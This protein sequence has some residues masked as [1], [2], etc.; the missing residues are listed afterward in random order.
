MPE[1]FLSD[2]ENDD[3]ESLFVAESEDAIA[4]AVEETTDGQKEGETSFAKNNEDDTDELTTDEETPAVNEEDQMKNTRRREAVFGSVAS[5][6]V[7]KLLRHAE[8][9]D[10]EAIAEMEEDPEIMHY[11]ESK[12]SF[13]KRFNALGLKD[14]GDEL[15]STREIIREERDK[16][17]IEAAVEETGV[18][19][20][21][22]YERIIKHA[23]RI[24]RDTG[25]LSNS[26]KA[27][28]MAVVGEAPKLLSYARSTPNRADKKS[29]KKEDEAI[30]SIM[31]KVGV[32]M[33]DEKLA[34][35]R[36]RGIVN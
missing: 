9:G 4:P 12:P 20:L 22:N 24:Y 21:D 28:H 33:T 32:N 16:E 3:S 7:D 34:E 18:K 11:V 2:E 29:T 10:T 19:G 1:P 17:K 6:A 5:R 8:N 23:S 27:A 30:K 15:K 25:N 14:S 26:V 35:A 31:A 13:N 36:R